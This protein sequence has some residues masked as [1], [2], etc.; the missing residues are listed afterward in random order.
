MEQQPLTQ[1]QQQLT[2]VQQQ[3]HSR[4]H[5]TKSAMVTED[6]YVNANSINKNS[7]KNLKNFIVVV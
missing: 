1:Q 6:I 2:Q 5:N 4:S 3:H 7:C